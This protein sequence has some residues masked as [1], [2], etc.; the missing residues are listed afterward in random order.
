M[1]VC[2]IIYMF[3]AC[4]SVDVNTHGSQLI[5]TPLAVDIYTPGTKKKLNHQS[6]MIIA[7]LTVAGAGL[8]CILTR[9]CFK[10]CF[11]SDQSV[12]ESDSS[13]EC[14]PSF[15]EKNANTEDTS[16]P[17]TK[18]FISYASIPTEN[19]IDREAESKNNDSDEEETTFLYEETPEVEVVVSKDVGIEVE[20][21]VQG[22]F[23]NFFTDSIDFLFPAMHESK[24][25][26][27]SPP[28]LIALSAYDT[29]KAYS[30]Y[31]R[32]S[33]R[34]S[35]GPKI[36]SLS[37]MK[38]KSFEKETGSSDSGNEEEKVEENNEKSYNS[39]LKKSNLPGEALMIRRSSSAENKVVV[40]NFVKEVRS[41]TELSD[42]QEGEKSSDEH[43]E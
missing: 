32:E 23:G 26:A 38:S 17:I 20:R 15:F 4:V 19:S 25:L 31:V 2:K 24:S 37:P 34:A 12:D 6:K 43:T 7:P 10:R 42:D 1:F 9:C 41:F 14:C 3:Q 16:I 30:L 40:F 21:P 35:E 27:R 5:Y 36:V 28:D 22:E 33:I 18:K 13:S 29:L 39:F 11:R 8:F